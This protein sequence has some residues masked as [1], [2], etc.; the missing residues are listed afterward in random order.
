MNEFIQ[1]SHD[2]RMVTKKYNELVDNCQKLKISV[3][4]KVK[5]KVD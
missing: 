2:A 4:E 1:N 5:E 3:Q